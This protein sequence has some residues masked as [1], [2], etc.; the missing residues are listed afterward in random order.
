MCPAYLRGRPHACLRVAETPPTAWPSGGCAPGRRTTPVPGRQDAP[1]D[2]RW[3]SRAERASH[4]LCGGADGDRM[5]RV[6]DGHRPPEH[7]VVF[8]DDGTR[9][10]DRDIRPHAHPVTDVHHRLLG[11]P[12]LAFHRQPCP[13]PGSTSTP[14]PTAILPEGG[15]T[16]AETGR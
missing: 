11:F 7:H 4:H 9:C 16:L 2:S 13:R 10:A 6:D 15:S 14:S 1:A 5:I 3:C 12:R 8:D